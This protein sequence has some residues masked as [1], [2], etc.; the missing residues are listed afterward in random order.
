MKEKSNKVVIYARVSTDKQEGGIDTQIN[1]CNEYIQRNNLSLARIFI[2]EAI[3]GTTDDRKAFKELKLYLEDHEVDVVVFKT[4]RIARD[5]VIWSD[6]VQVCEKYKRAIHEVSLGEVNT[7]TALGQMQSSIQI[8]FAQFER[9]TFMERSRAGMI[10]N[11]KE[12]N[13]VFRV[14]LGYKVI[15]TKKNAKIIT[16]SHV[17]K[18]LQQIFLDYA[19]EKITIQEAVE[20]LRKNG[21]KANKSSI[22]KIL[23]NE[24]YA[25]YYEYSKWGVGLT[26]GNHEAI[27]PLSVIQK[28][29]EK[30]GKNNKISKDENFALKKILFCIDCKKNLQTATFKKAKFPYYY[31]LGKD[32]SMNNKYFSPKVIDQQIIEDLQNVK[33]TEEIKQTITLFVNELITN[34]EKILESKQDTI[35]ESI[36]RNNKLLQVC[37]MKISKLDQPELIEKFQIEYNGIKKNILALE[38]ELM[39]TPIDTIEPLKNQIN[40]A[41]QILENPASIYENGD[42]IVKLAVVKLVYNNQV[43]YDPIIKRLNLV[44]SDL[45][46]EIA[47]KN[48][49]TGGLAVYNGQQLNHMFELLVKNLC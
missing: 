19:D 31:C 44:F 11:L 9:K 16:D 21:T 24:F 6:F 4:D 49:L 26:R 1:A 25:G 35:K 43:Y 17:T 42:K 30:G 40:Q 3:S 27:I 13:W 14:P 38:E 5:I 37:L 22:H 2:D 7:T 28:I 8:L 34:K 23:K 10:K 15:G 47:T 33:L 46:Q 39:L 12:G 32:C 41:M 29:K 48:T 36:V 20:V 18:I 45:A